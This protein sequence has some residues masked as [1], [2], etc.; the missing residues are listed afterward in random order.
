MKRCSK[1]KVE[2]ELAEFT[3]YTSGRPKSWCKKCHRNHSRRM[4]REQH[5]KERTRGKEKTRRL[6]A[7]VVSWYS[8]TAN[9]CACCGFSDIRALCI[10][11]IYGGGSRHVKQ[12]GIGTLY[13][14]LKRN[15]FPPGFQVLCHNC[16]WIKR[17]EEGECERA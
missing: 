6:K 15:N 11:H 4:Y 2:K 13:G 10:D 5:D 9:C 3:K 16:N 14:W 17:A 12:I 8:D 7:V 1:C